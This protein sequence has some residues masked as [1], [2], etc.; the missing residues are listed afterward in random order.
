MLEIDI[1]GFGLLVLQHLVTD[2]NGTLS[3]G[4]KLLPGV[5]GQLNRLAMI[6]GCFSPSTQYLE[7]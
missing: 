3:V 6:D 2:F 1:P 7:V 4:G 5:K